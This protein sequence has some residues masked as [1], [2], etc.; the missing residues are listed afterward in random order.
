M[1]GLGKLFGERGYI[2][3]GKARAIGLAGT[4]GVSTAI[5]VRRGSGPAS[6]GS[7]V[8]GGA[9]KVALIAA[10]VPAEGAAAIVPSMLKYRRRCTQVTD[11]L[12]RLFGRERA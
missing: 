5:R 6:Y 12:H 8:T 7:G 3:V 2:I 10:P 4:S 9:A 11:R 1:L